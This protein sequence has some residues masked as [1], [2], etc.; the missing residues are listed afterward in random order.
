MVGNITM[1]IAVIACS[2]GDSMNKLEIGSD[3]QAPSAGRFSDVIMSEEI[4][5]IPIKKVNTSN[6]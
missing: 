4:Q 2:N 6:I 5:R 3:V 1:V